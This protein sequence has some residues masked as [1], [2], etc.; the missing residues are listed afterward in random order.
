V[1][2]SSLPDNEDLPYQEI[3]IRFESRLNNA[4]VRFSLRTP[5]AELP[6][7][8]SS[9]LSSEQVDRALASVD[10]FSKEWVQR[11]DWSDALDP[12][13]EMGRALFLALFQGSVGE[14]YRVAS[15]AALSHGTGLR[16]R[17]VMNDPALA[18]L[19]WEFLYDP[20]RRDFIALSAR[21][22]IVRDWGIARPRSIVSA[23]PEGHHTSAND[24]V[25]MKHNS[26]R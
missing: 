4:R 18:V 12:V 20:A 21:A 16:L 26:D 5:T 10:R 9:P 19:P 24:S 23:P 11:S 13:Q 15:E 6:G 8:F 17:F 7:V 2:V 3:E 22:S 14:A 25:H 1:A